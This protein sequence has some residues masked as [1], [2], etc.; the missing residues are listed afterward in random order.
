[1][2]I[3]SDTSE[4]EEVKDDEGF[5]R[6]IRETLEVMASTPDSEPNGNGFG[7]NNS[8]L[9]MGFLKRGDNNGGFW[10]GG[11]VEACI[12]NVGSED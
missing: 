6:D 9:N 12:A 11:S 1:M 5:I 2:D 8:S 10:C 3:H 4:I 7:A